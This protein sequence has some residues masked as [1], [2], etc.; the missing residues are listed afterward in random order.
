MSV[1]HGDPL[2]LKSPNICHF[3]DLRT[4]VIGHEHQP[5]GTA[6][7]IEERCMIDFVVLV[8]SSPRSFTA[9]RRVWRIDKKGDFLSAQIALYKYMSI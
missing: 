1:L 2:D 3:Y 5:S 8:Q 4:I 9:A 7:Q 6:E